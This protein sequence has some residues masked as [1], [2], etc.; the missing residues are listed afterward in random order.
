M[1]LH[2]DSRMEAGRS[3]KVSLIRPLL[4]ARRVVR[5]VF[6]TTVRAAGIAAGAEQWSGQE[7]CDCA[8]AQTF[9]NGVAT[10]GRGEYAIEQ[11]VWQPLTHSGNRAAQPNLAHLFRMGLGVAQDFVEGGRL[12]LPSSEGQS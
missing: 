12:V 6:C 1:A 7:P 2:A 9:T 8:S 4:L 3:S 11:E 5:P 10:Y